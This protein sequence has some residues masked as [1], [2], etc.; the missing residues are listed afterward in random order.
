MKI[1]PRE[2]VLSPWL[3]SQGCAVYGYRALARLISLGSGCDCA[4]AL[5][6]MAADKPRRS[7]TRTGNASITRAGKAKCNSERGQGTTSGYLQIITSDSEHGL[8]TLQRS[9]ANILWI[10]FRT[11][12]RGNSRYIST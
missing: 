11:R 3:P 7:Y 12:R 8:P 1:P 6:Q 9:R 5:F 10:I 2:V 4:E